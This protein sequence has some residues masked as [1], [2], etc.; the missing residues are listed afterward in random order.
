MSSSLMFPTVYSLFTEDK[1]LWQFNNCELSYSHGS[2]LSV[3]L[4]FLSLP[5]HPHSS[6]FNLAFAGPCRVSFLSFPPLRPSCARSDPRRSFPSDQL[7]DP[8]A[9]RPVSRVAQDWVWR[10]RT[11]CVCI[12][13][14]LKFSLG[15]WFVRAKALQSAA[16]WSFFPS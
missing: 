13:K 10:R 11:S 1:H 8:V 6:V 7:L 5:H 3:G 12:P 2:A 15:A 16:V 4:A 14:S 9:R